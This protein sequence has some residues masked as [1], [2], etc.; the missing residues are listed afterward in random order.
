METQISGS[1]SNSDQSFNNGGKMCNGG[2][3]ELKELNDNC[4]DSETSESNSGIQHRAKK[5]RIIYDKVLK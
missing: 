1:N 2:A 5:R 4:G 3:S